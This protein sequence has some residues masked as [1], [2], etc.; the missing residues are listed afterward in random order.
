MYTIVFLLVAV[1][2]W[3]MGMYGYSFLQYIPYVD[4][5]P[6]ESSSGIFTIY[7]ITFPLFV[8][9]F[10]LAISLIGV[11]NSKDTRAKINDMG[12][13]LKLPLIV[14]LM[15]ADFFI[16]LEFFTVYAWAALF[17]AGFFILVQLVLL[18]D[19]AYSWSDSWVRKMEGDSEFDEPK[20]QWYFALLGVTLFLYLVALGLDVF[21]YV[22]YC[23]DDCW[24]NSLIIT[25]ILLICIFQSAFSVIPCIQNFNPRVG[26]LQAAVFTVY[27]TYY[28]FSAILS[29]PNHCGTITLSNMDDSSTFASWVNAI[30]ILFGATFT[31]VAVV[32]ASLRAGNSDLV[33][34]P[35]ADSDPLPEGEIEEVDE[36]EF[37]DD[38]KYQCSYNYSL[39]HFA[40]AFGAMYLAMLLT[41]W[42]VITGNS[43]WNPETDSGWTAVGIKLASCCAAALLYS[44]TIFAPAILPDR[45]WDL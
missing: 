15:I 31:V 8:F 42:S 6:N 25:G 24:W 40:F 20:K 45:D 10:L 39:F 1:L 13:A 41:N 4:E 14:C 23:R 2:A 19:F 26:L 18:V 28:A 11:K 37:M 36:D 32:Y 35:A 34:S 21:M 38:E 9:H 33:P 5:G 30:S 12:W 3:L 43:D 7:R 29:E 16:P 22:V 17:G 27:C 44:W